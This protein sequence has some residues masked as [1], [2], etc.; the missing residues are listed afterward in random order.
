MELLEK[1]KEFMRTVDAQRVKRSLTMLAEKGRPPFDYEDGGAEAS[2]WD[3]EFE[4]LTEMLCAMERGGYQTAWDLVQ[5]LGPSSDEGECYAR[6]ALGMKEENIKK[7][8][9]ESVGVSR[10]QKKINSAETRRNLSRLIW[11]N[12]YVKRRKKSRKEVVANN[13]T[14]TWEWI[15][16]EDRLPEDYGEVICCTKNKV[17]MQ[18][19]YNPKHRLFNVYGDNIECAI[20][21]THWMPLPEPPKMKGGAE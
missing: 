4:S 19:V 16:V 15:S 13:A 7:S 14:T 20:D 17:I 6:M 1:E 18:I 5:A 12:F 10:A 21:V 2:Y 11:R 8:R 9:K 3:Y